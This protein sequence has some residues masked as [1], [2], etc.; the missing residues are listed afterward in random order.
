M[1][2]RFIEWIEENKKIQ[3]LSEEM[4]NNLLDYLKKEIINSKEKCERN[5]LDKWK[6]T[7]GNCDNLDFAD[8]REVNTYVIQHFFDR[9][10]RMLLT[11]YDMY[12]RKM[13]PIKKNIYILDIG[14]G[15]ASNLFAIC[16]FYK[17]IKEFGNEYDIEKFKSINLK[18]DYVEKSSG[19]RQWIHKFQ[20]FLLKKDKYYEI[21]FHH[22]SFENFS[23]ISYIISS[24]HYYRNFRFDLVVNSNFFTKANMQDI[25][26][27]INIIY[28]KEIAN[29]I[30]KIKLN[31]L[32]ITLSSVKYSFHSDFKKYLKK[33]KSFRSKDLCKLKEIL[34]VDSDEF[35]TE[36]T[37]IRKDTALNL[38]KYFKVILEILYSYE[39]EHEEIKKQ[40]NKNTS[41]EWKIIVMKKI[42]WIKRKIV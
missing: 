22:G 40:I 30:R 8:E 42:I 10:Q 18:I 34:D 5:I 25:D 29:T 2:S 14:T 4:K 39:I 23:N 24:N 15:P 21:P 35:R 27:K 13:L 1:N 20:E 36:I 32:F 41:Q 28:E 6:E 19:F 38:K 11:L 9:Y 26:N 3:E 12:Y 31:G 16:D 17:L 37:Q 7:L 33:I